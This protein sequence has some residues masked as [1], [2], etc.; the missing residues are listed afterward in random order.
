MW[1]KHSY[2]SLLTQNFTTDCCKHDTNWPYVM[3][4]VLPSSMP[5][6]SVTLHEETED[7]G[8]VTVT[9]VHFPFQ[10]I[11]Q[12]IKINTITRIRGSSRWS[13]SLI[14]VL[15]HLTYKSINFSIAVCSKYPCCLSLAAKWLKKGFNILFM[16]QSEFSSLKKYLWLTV[17]LQ[18]ITLLPLHYVGVLVEWHEDFTHSV[19]ILFIYFA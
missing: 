16:H 11:P 18:H 5:C 19:F 14:T 4:T 17:H 1:N 15:R 7:I 6:S 9:L 2:Q 8:R 13:P 12:T 10:V 3:R